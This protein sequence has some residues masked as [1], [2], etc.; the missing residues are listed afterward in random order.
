[1][2]L[3]PWLCDSPDGV[4]IDEK[5]MSVKIL[6][7]KCPITCENKPIIENGSSKVKYLFIHNNKVYLKPND[8]YYAQ[9]QILMNCTGTFLCDFLSILPKGTVLYL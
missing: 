5:S 9:C 7:I 8:Q 2:P 4:V 3:H 1:M 6:E